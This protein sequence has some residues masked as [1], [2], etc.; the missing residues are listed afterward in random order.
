MAASAH[1]S[2]FRNRLARRPL[3]WGPALLASLGLAVGIA[4]WPL[5]GVAVTA[6]DVAAA[7]Q[8]RTTTVWSSPVHLS[9]GSPLAES[10]LENLLEATGYRHAA[11]ERSDTDRPGQLHQT[12]S[13][14]GILYE[15]TTF[16]G[17]HVSLKI[18]DGRLQ[19]LEQ[20]DQPTD[21]FDL[22]PVALAHVLGPDRI[23]RRPLPFDHIDPD[24]V[25][26]IVAAEDDGFFQHHGLSIT[27]IARAALGNL[28]AGRVEQGASTITQ[29]LARNLFLTLERSWIRKAREAHLALG[30]ERRWTKEQI[31]E[32]YANIIYLGA[33]FGRQLVGVE[34]ASR[35]Y[36]GVGADQLSV[37]EAAL[38][39]GMISAPARFDPV[40]H[41]E[42]AKARRDWVLGRMHE[43]GHLDDRDLAGL[44]SE[45]IRLRGDDDLIWAD[46]F[47]TQSLRRVER[48]L[49]G[50]PLV[51]GGLQI[52]TTLDWFEQARAIEAASTTDTDHELALVSIDPANGDVLTYL[53]GHPA[54]RSYFDRASEARRQMGSL[55]KPFAFALAFQERRLLPTSDVLDLPL[56]VRF[57]ETT[58]SPRNAKGRYK[59]RT[60]VAN[61]LRHSLNAASLR[62]A[63][64]GGLDQLDATLRQ[65]GL[66]P[67][68]AGPSLA[69]GAVEATP[70][71]VALAYRSFATLGH[72]GPLRFVRSLVDHD[73]TEIDLPP[74]ETQAILEPAAAFLTAD[75]LRGVVRGGTAWR[76][77]RALPSS[78]I[79][80]KTGT[81][82]DGRDAWFVGLAPDRLTVV[83][84]GRDDFAEADLWGG[85]DAAGLF[86]KYA[87]RSLEARGTQSIDPPDS[88]R[89]AEPLCPGQRAGWI[90]KDLLEEPELECP[91]FPEIS[92]QFAVWQESATESDTVA[93]RPHLAVDRGTAGA[94]SMPPWFRQASRATLAVRQAQLVAEGWT[95]PEEDSAPPLVEDIHLDGPLGLVQ[96]RAWL[97]TF[98]GM[99]TPTDSSPAL[100]RTASMQPPIST[101]G[102]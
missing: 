34:A 51:G 87:E 100:I 6:P 45:P 16:H 43:L 68:G 27:G 41:P 101:S 79:A 48:H 98:D 36:F 63:L 56:Q 31:F 33:R 55:V 9:A 69:L 84:N 18:A 73:G 40:A 17:H 85:R 76:V 32:N 74:A 21:S 19:E 60:S 64:A 8:P 53:G 13:D 5:L 54:T 30:I 42:A 22:G 99:F 10:E 2:A 15:L 88:V 1:L 96:T 66:T 92:P 47:V 86:V 12:R 23:D 25:H 35:A 57:D 44:T 90:P 95:A 29:Q 58:W 94:G 11:G 83:W 62:V 39:A 93:A 91:S 52:Y 14:D 49:D 71:E 81:S 72:T 50:R 78:R 82:N 3:L 102:Q 80:A 28:R 37:E 65:I 38:L 59:G 7:Q 97:A 61:A 77:G 70:L 75:V 26:A 4:S 89:W 20:G 67:Q 24:L 46:H